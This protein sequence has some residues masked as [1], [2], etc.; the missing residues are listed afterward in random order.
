MVGVRRSS[1]NTSTLYGD[2]PTRLQCPIGPIRFQDV[3]NGL[4]SSYNTNIHALEHSIRAAAQ[5]SFRLHLFSAFLA[6]AG[7]VAQIILLRQRIAP[8][9][10]L[11]T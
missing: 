11:K 2:D 7:M 10:P 4:A 9:I 3:I 1:H 5:L 6:L 8:A